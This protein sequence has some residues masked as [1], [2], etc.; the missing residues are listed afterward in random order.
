MKNSYVAR[1]ANQAQRGFTLIELMIVVVIA[2]ILAAIG[3]PS[4][5][6]YV[7]KSNRAAAESFML[8]IANKQEQYMLDA[9]SYSQTL[10]TGGLGL[11]TPTDVARNYS[12]SI[13]ATNPAGAPATYSIT[14]TPKAVQNDTQCG[15]VALDQT[16]AKG[17][18][19][20]TDASGNVTYTGT[21]MSCSV[22]ATTC[23]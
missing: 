9:R 2:G 13:A 1:T 12:I 3:I 15:V 4:Y 8:S 6:S 11:T 14:A 21:T 10:G 7:V 5:R 22:P 16:A 23:W 17:A 20:S 19:C 18:G